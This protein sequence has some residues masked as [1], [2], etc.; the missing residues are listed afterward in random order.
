MAAL[1]KDNMSIKSDKWIKYQS[2]NNYLITPFTDKQVNK[3]VISYG[4][5]SYG[6]DVRIAPEFKIFTNINNTVLDPKDLDESSFVDYEGD[7]CIIPPNSFILS[8]TIEK[9][10]IPKNVLAIFM[11]KSTYAR[12][13]IVVGVTPLEPGW[14]GTVTIEISNTTPLPAMVYANEGIGQLLFF[15]SDEQCETTYAD[16]LGKYQYQSAITLPFVRK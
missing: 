15:E 3:G 10:Q 8:R 6:Y 16:R 2:L 13:G 7:V 12:I 5:S 4:L 9:I 11:A 14:Q 1:E